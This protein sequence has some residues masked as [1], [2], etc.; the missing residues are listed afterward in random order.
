M[1][2]RE[3][4]KE[5]QV[6]GEGEDEQEGKETGELREWGAWKGEKAGRWESV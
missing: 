3:G 2:A 5:K 4:K 1:E 6:N